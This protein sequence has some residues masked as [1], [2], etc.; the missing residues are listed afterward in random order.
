MK[1][2]RLIIGD[3]LNIRHSWFSEVNGEITYVMMEIRS[4]TDYVRHHIQKLLGVLGA[5]RQ[6]SVTLQQAGHNVIYIKL[7]DVSNKQSFSA[8]LQD[9]ISKNEF[10]LFEY[11]EPDEYRVDQVLKKFCDH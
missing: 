5:M 10:D 9:I 11:Q 6:F 7:N 8:N 2:L 1:I 3:Q 4:E